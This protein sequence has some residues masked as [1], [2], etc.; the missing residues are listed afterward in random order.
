MTIVNWFACQHI[1]WNNYA[2]LINYFTE[3]FLENTNSEPP[4]LFIRTTLVKAKK[5]VAISIESLEVVYRVYNKLCFLA[6]NLNYCFD[7][8]ILITVPYMFVIIMYKVFF[9]ITRIAQ[10]QH[11]RYRNILECLFNMASFVGFVVP[12]I[13]TCDKAEEFKQILQRLDSDIEKDNE[14]HDMMNLIYYQT[15]HLPIRFSACG[16]FYLNRK[17]LFSVCSGIFTYLVMLIQIDTS[18]F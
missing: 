1:L 5:S 16:V 8:Q 12:S 18:G 4:I 7:W 13:R 14:V 10:D 3:N 2:L 15:L 6:R 9:I 11:V 17:L